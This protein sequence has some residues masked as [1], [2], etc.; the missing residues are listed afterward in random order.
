M[1][2]LDKINSPSDIKTLSLSEKE[3]LCA[4]LRNEIINVCS[5]NGGHLASSLGAV[6]LTVALY[7]IY[8]PFKDKLVFDDG[9]QSYAHKILSGRRASFSTLRRFGGISGFP[10]PYESEADPVVAGHA[11][12]SIA[13]AMGLAAART[14]NNEKY[15]VVAIIGDGAMT[16]GPAFEGLCNCAASN[17]PMVII[18]ND[19]EMSIEKSVGGMSLLLSRLRVRPGYIAAKQF[20]RKIFKPGTISHGL[21][22][23]IKAFVKRILLPEN[24][25]ENMGFYY[26]GP[27][28]GHKINELE[29]SIAYARKMNCPVVLHIVTKKG[30]GYNYAENEPDRY[31]GVAPFN[32][33][34]GISP[35][36]P[37]SFSS[38]LGNE[39]CRLAKENSK[40]V[41]ITAAMES[42]TGLDT[43]SKEYKERFFD[44]GIA[45]GHGVSLAAGMAA[46]G[47]I[48]VFAVYST[49]LQRG[50]DMLIHDISLSGLHAVFAVDR[51]GLVGADGE[52]HQGLFDVGYLRLVPGMKIYAPANYAELSS[53]LNEAVN[54]T[55]PC[56][57]R[58]PRGSEGE[59][60]E[61]CSGA[62][63]SIIRN[64]SDCLIISYGVLINEALKAAED[65]SEKGIETAVIKLNRLDSLPF[66]ELNNLICAS[67]KT[68]IVEELAETGC[69]GEYIISGIAS[70]NTG[71]FNIKL[72]NLG[73]G[74][75]EH[76]TVSE[77]RKKYGIDANGIVSSVIGM[78]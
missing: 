13:N 35:S 21:I 3:Q 22:H 23:N 7:S 6:E 75:I 65:L 68:V 56:A 49:F 40:I 32:S 31:H 74:I 12:V 1:S 70:I 66:S 53:M 20:F 28:N 36:S 59:F 67:P 57:V 71:S 14:L 58:Y 30:K 26:I 9:H 18:L 62:P 76:G 15:S 54:E 69:I 64:G 63:F 45:E 8:D 37:A 61:N 10:R 24:I 46:G 48:P 39:L 38:C 2:I 72:I 47:L 78:E 50:F 4:E 60:K 55:G 42:G 73:N 52:T 5:Q 29:T 41:A 34:K 27:V 43:F 77:L 44:V 16:G 11:S 33:D 19:N 17:E 25:F 51:A